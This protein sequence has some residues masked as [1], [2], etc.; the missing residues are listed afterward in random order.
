MGFLNTLRT[1]WEGRR[2]TEESDRERV[3]GYRVESELAYEILGIDPVTHETQPYDPDS[4]EKF[5]RACSVDDTLTARLRV[6][7]TRWTLLSGLQRSAL[8]R[9]LFSQKSK[10]RLLSAKKILGGSI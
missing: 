5:V 8:L 9:D 10:L 2:T 7:C 4:V 1:V 3:F 6:R